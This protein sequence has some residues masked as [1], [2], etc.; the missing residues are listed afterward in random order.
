MVLLKTV[1]AQASFIAALMF[2]L[3]AIYTSEYFG[4]FH[5]SFYSLD[6]SF[7]ELVLQSLQLLKYQFLVAAVL[8]L[9][10]V[11]A[12]PQLS[13]LLSWSSRRAH[14]RPAAS[15]PL[16]WLSMAIT[17][18]GLLLLIFWSEIQPYAWTA[19]LTIAAGLLLGQSR[20]V[21][22]NPPDGL[23]RRAVVVFASGV[24]LFWAL[25][26]ATQQFGE[27]DAK[28]HAADV[29]DWTSVVVLSSKPLSLPPPG[30]QEEKLP[31]ENL[32]LPYRYT[33]LRLLLERHGRYYVVP[34][35][36]KAK[37]DA[38]YVIQESND[39]WIALRPG[40]QPAS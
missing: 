12:G 3:G 14:T 15:T 5:L 25:T 36:W 2:Y 23:R 38:V 33:G 22:G 20:N 26:Q 24:F 27:E 6:F 1:V 30:V 35:D 19:P 10:V 13:R 29:V 7:A 21:R 11:A 32:L 40:T 8:I 16:A 28:A 31:R 39:L 18:A 4:Y 17:A 34:A 37:T 9:I